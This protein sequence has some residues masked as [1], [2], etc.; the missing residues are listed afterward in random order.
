VVK[1]GELDG[2]SRGR[3]ICQVSEINLWKFVKSNKNDF[4]DAEAI[5]KPSSARSD[6]AIWLKLNDRLTGTG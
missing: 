5:A 6:S 2:D 1:R 4:V 3:K